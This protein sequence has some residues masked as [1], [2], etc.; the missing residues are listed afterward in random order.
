L[1]QRIDLHCHSRH[2]HDGAL[3]VAALVERAT[4]IGLGGLALTDHDSIEGHGELKGLAAQYP[5]MVLIRGCEVTTAEGHLLAYGVDELPVQGLPLDETLKRVDEQNGVAVLAHPFRLG[6]GVDEAAIRK[7]EG[8]SLEATNGRSNQRC[9]RKAMA[10]AR[11]LG[12][13]V[14]GGG[15]T[16]VAI[17]MGRAWTS[18]SVKV[19]DEKSALDALRIGSVT[20]G[21]RGLN[22]AQQVRSKVRGTHRWLKRKLGAA[23]SNSNRTA[24]NDIE[25]IR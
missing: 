7:S 19:T 5:D 3:T 13:A 20:C 23:G 9:N 17:E 14:T 25:K 10:I 12:R 4:A 16:H 2:S 11:E 22:H 1:E 18:F 15:D 24:S 21:G 8:C 6:N